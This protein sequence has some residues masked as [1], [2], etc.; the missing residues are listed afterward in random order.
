MSVCAY[1]WAMCIQNVWFWYHTW[2][3][4]RLLWRETFVCFHVCVCVFFCPAHPCGCHRQWVGCIQAL[5]P[6]VDWPAIPKDCHLKVLHHRVN[7]L[8]AKHTHKLRF[9]YTVGSKMLT[10]LRLHK[11][12]LICQITS[13]TTSESKV[14]DSA[15]SYTCVHQQLFII[16]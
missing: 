13:D 7:H 14:I 9:S 8:P 3:T 6:I 15:P 5:L 11:W 10:G 1:A 4:F 16:C 2:F 12:C